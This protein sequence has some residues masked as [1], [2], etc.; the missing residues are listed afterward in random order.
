[1]PKKRVAVIGT[2]HAVIDQVDRKVA[3]QMVADGEAVWWD[4]GWSIRLVMSGVRGKSAQPGQRS[5]ESYTEA[6]AAIP[7][8]TPNETMAATECW[9]GKVK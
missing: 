3:R 1:M 5:I 6:S 4:G 2:G 9:A 7:D 8:D